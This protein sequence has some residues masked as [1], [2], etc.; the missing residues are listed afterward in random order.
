MWTFIALLLPLALAADQSF[1]FFINQTETLFSG[2]SAQC[3]L[4]LSVSIPECPQELLNLLGSSQFY[5]VQNETM[6][7]ILCREACP[8]ALDTYRSSV[9][10]ACANDPQPRAGYPATYWVDAVSSVQTQMCLKDSTA[11]QYCTQFLEQTLGDAADPTDL[12]GGYNTEQLC[13]ECIVNLF[14]H[15]QSTPYSNYDVEMSEAWAEIQARCNLEYPTATPT[16]ETNV[17]SLGNYAPSGYATAACV[18]SRTYEV[19]SGDNCVDISQTNHVSTGSLITLNSL[20][21]DCTNLLLGQTLCLPPE[22]DDYVVQSGDTCIDI[23]AKFPDVS[24]QQIVAWNPTINPYCTNLLVDQN[25]CVG[26]PGGIANFTTVPGA[27]ATQTG[28]YATET[29]TRSSPVAEGTTTRCG[30]YY[31]VQPGD[32]CEI[33]ALNQTVSLDLF[34]AMNPQIDSSCSNLLSGFSY[35]VQPTR[36]FNT[37]TTSPVIPAPTSTPPGTTTEC[38]EW[39]IIQ[40]GDYCAKVTDQFGITFAQFQAWNPAVADDCSNLLLDVAYCVNGA[41]TVAST[42]AAAVASR[43]TLDARLER[44]RDLAGVVRA[45]SG[46]VQTKAPGSAGGGVAIGWPGVNSPRLRQQMGLGIDIS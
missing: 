14:Q 15:Q 19:V 1:F 18:G 23:A 26:P 11:G 6:M 29:A 37:T 41:L 4:A 43:R 25:I 35:C 39:Y 32:Y 3:N 12:L 20:R 16:L 21:L 30:K 17:T 24:Y 34:L 44:G 38:Y 9:Q 10:E 31:L 22:C 2:I 8:P 5:T 40:S 42:P 36:D 27:T 33:V 13:L 7:D 46:P 45:R 28:L